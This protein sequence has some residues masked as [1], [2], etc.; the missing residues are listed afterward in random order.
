M[1]TDACAARSGFAGHANRG[2]KG[3]KGGEEERRAFITPPDAVPPIAFMQS[4]KEEKRRREKSANHHYI[5]CGS[6]G[7]SSEEEKGE[8]R[9]GKKKKEGSASSFSSHRLPIRR[10]V[11]IEAGFWRMRGVG[12]GGKGMGGPLY[13]NYVTSVRLALRGS[14]PCGEEKKERKKKLLASCWPSASL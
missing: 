3:R 12:E 13:F 4:R 10:P 5:P 6:L 1:K 14:A 8:E 11:V 2:G 9:G 7:L